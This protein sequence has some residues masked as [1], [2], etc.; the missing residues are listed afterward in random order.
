MY[1]KLKNIIDILKFSSKRTQ[2]TNA[3]KSDVEISSVHAIQ[4][5]QLGKVISFSYDKS[6]IQMSA[7]IHYGKSFKLIEVKKVHF[8]ESQI[9][10]HGLENLATNA[11]ADFHKK[12][13]G[14][15]TKVVLT[16]TGEETLYR[17]FFMPDLKKK[18]LKSA[19]E[20]EVKKLI[21]FPYEQCIFDYRIIQ[22]VVHDEKTQ[23]KISLHATTLANI[24]QY[25]VPFK[26][27]NIP[28]DRIYHAQDTIGQLLGLLK[29]YTNKNNYTLINIGHKATEIS[30]YTGRTLIFSRSSRLNTDMLKG[31]DDSDVRYEYF[32]ESIA[33]EVQNS[34]DY[35]AGQFTTGYN[36][37]FLVYGDFAYSDKLLNLLNEKL[38]VTLE[39]F[40]I[41]DL[42]I[43]F[44]EEH[45]NERYPISLPVL[46]TAVN[47][48]ILPDLLP[49]DQKRKRET[50][51]RNEYFKAALGFSALIFAV[52][53]MYMY[54]RI[55]NL[56]DNYSLLSVQVQE[57][58]QSKAFHTY[59][60]IKR[61]ISLDQD[62]MELAKE[63][64]S[65]LNLNLKELSRITPKKIKLFHIDYNPQTDMD[66]YFLQGVVRS[67]DIPPEITLAEFIESL[68]SSPFY[69]DVKIIKHIKKKEKHTF[70]I[71]FQIKMRGIV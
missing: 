17:T 46:A 18:E 63:D 4:R 31:T 14:R 28:V 66:N 71:E 33:N 61:E 19:I 2:K 57:F 55:D 58:E 26:R 7:A 5:H 3:K 45:V 1:T 70:E 49:F 44:Y 43:K 32:A 64:P 41:L 40:P 68:K 21:P 25:L 39:R 69:D 6:A 59:N 10:E 47:H 23:L 27:L 15:F 60:L 29:D 50:A 54:Q 67:S 62:Y 13:G 48:S 35:Y 11:I 51:E 37:K 53:W 9:S 24:E 42:K 38:E 16:M 56:K 12:H 20:F 34:L 8:S 22:K 36:T 52:S 30:F 65:H